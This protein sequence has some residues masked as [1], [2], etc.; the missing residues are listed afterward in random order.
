MDTSGT[1]G[2]RFTIFVPFTGHPKR[3]WIVVEDEAS[4][5]LVDP[6]FEVDVTLRTDRAALYRTYLGRAS[7]AE[8]HREGHVELNC[9]RASV[10][11]FFDAFRQSPVA[12]IVETESA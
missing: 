11:S 6:G 10:R 8:A 4:L 12:S 5:C 7:L 1:P 3:Y 9:S 2:R